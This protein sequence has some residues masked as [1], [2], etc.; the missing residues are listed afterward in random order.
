MSAENHDAELERLK[1]WEGLFET[2]NPV[3]ANAEHA[4]VLAKRDALFAV[5]KRLTEDNQRLT[6]SLRAMEA[7]RQ[8]LTARLVKAEGRAQ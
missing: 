6:E 7:S 2:T 5:N 8:A 1:Q 4:A 3:Q